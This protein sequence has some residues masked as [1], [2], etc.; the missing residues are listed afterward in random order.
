MDTFNLQGKSFFFMEIYKSI[1]HFFFS[2][3]GFKIVGK[4]IGKSDG[5]NNQNLYTY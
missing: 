1:T 2:K 3:V 5:T 4:L